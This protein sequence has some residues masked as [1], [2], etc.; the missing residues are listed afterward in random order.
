MRE[1]PLRLFALVAAVSCWVPALAQTTGF[2]L[3]EYLAPQYIAPT[4]APSSIVIAGKDE[5]GARLVVT[6]R[7]LIGDKPV[8]GVSLYVFHT[9]ARGK[10]SRATD[11]NRIGELDPRLHGALRTDSQG[12]YR[13]ETTRPGSYDDGASHVHYVVSADGYEPLLIAL[14]FEDDPIVARQRRAGRPDLNPEA[15]KNG[16]CKSRPDC[17]LTRPVARDRQGVAHVTRDIQMVKK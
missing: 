4:R 17:V 12:R 9:D 1:T 16:P 14:Q 5:P 13:Y 11:D 6:G 3:K 8:A 15:F 10:Y 7:T 2:T